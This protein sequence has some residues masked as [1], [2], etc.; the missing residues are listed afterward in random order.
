MKT[1]RHCVMTQALE[2]S[3]GMAKDKTKLIECNQ[4]L[5]VAVNTFLGLQLTNEVRAERF[6]DTKTPA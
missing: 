5:C 2:A 4:G 1:A 3:N 6:S